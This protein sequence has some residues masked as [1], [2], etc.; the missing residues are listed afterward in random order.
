MLH[1]AMDSLAWGR[2]VTLPVPIRAWDDVTGQFYF[3]APAQA[4]ALAEFARLGDIPQA[5]TA[6]DSTHPDALS[7]CD[8][9]DLE[10][11][12]EFHLS[13]LSEAQDKSMD[14]VLFRHGGV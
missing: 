10:W 1:R 5:V 14:L 8:P 12:L 3:D 11:T 6:L 13:V 4:S 7:E 9:A 2:E